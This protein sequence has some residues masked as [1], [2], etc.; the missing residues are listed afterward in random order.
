M[1]RRLLLGQGALKFKFEVD[2]E[3]VETLIRR[4]LFSRNHNICRALPR[5]VVHIS[6][7]AWTITK[8]IYLLSNEFTIRVNLIILF[9]QGMMTVTNL[10][11]H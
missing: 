7:T 9:A 5:L 8:T 11:C 10:S 2:F 4:S 1:E 6:T 3:E